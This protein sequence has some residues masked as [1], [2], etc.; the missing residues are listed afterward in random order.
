MSFFL[1]AASLVA[2]SVLVWAFIAAT[3]GS[4]E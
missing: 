1:I 2:A 3:E 4:D